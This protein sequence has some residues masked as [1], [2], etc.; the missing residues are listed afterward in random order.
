M[1]IA[2]AFSRVSFAMLT[3]GA[4]GWAL[5][6]TSRLTYHTVSS[7]LLALC[8]LQWSRWADVWSV[9]AWRRRLHPKTRATPQEYGY[10]VWVPGLIIGVVFLA[11]A[12]AKL[13]EGGIGWITNGTVKYHF[14]SDSRQ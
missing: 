2:G 11:A 5:L 14:L 10:T 4:F 13:R 7:F 3:V 1:L 8:F 9:D 6:F 12:I